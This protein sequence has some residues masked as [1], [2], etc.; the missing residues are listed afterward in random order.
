MENKTQILL[1]RAIFFFGLI[2]F[3]ISAYL[4]YTYTQEKPIVCLN[5]GCEVVRDSPY[6]YVLGIPLPAFGLAMYLLVI[7]VSFLRT[8]LDKKEHLRLAKKLIFVSSALGFLTSAYLTYLEAFVIKAYCIWCIF[9][10]I[11]VTLIFILS[12]YELRRFK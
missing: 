10:A 1:N 2:G 5:T 3:A 8:T 4:F 11:V 12:A 9:S 7:V 6:A